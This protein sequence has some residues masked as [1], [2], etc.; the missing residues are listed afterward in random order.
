MTPCKEVKSRIFCPASD[1]TSK[2]RH[3]RTDLRRRYD[4][5]VENP[6]NDASA[7]TLKKNKEKYKQRY[8]FFLQN[9]LQLLRNSKHASSTE[10]LFFSELNW[11]YQISRLL[12]MSANS[13]LFAFAK[14]SK[15]T[16]T[17]HLNFWFLY[18]CNLSK[19]LYQ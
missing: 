4:K 6:P 9:W 10:F 11:K 7:E 8:L 16:S 1:A 17:P 14:W 3:Q 19:L 18:P 13:V 12:W 2:P 5:H 15:S